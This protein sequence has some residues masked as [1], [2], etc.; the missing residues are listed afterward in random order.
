MNNRV[1]IEEYFKVFNPEPSKYVERDISGYLKT[2]RRELTITLIEGSQ[3]PLSQKVI[4]FFTREGMIDY[5]G[6]DID[7]HDSNG[8][9]DNLPTQILVERFNITVKIIGEHPSL[10]FRSPRGIHAYWFFIKPIPNVLLHNTLDD[11]FEGIKHIEILPTS[12][13]SLRVPSQDNYFDNNLQKRDFPGFDCLVRYPYKAIFKNGFIHGKENSD[14]KKTYIPK[15]NYT[16]LSLIQ[17]ENSLLPLKN[18]Q[19]NAVYTKLVAKYKIHGL[20]ESQAYARF[21]DLINRSP[22]YTGPLIVDL[23]KRISTSYSRMASIGLSQAKS[24]SDLHRDPRIRMA[25]EFCIKRLGLD[26]PKRGKMKKSMITFLL[27]IISWKLACDNIFK[28]YETANYWEYLYNGSWFKHKEGYY[29]LPYSLLRKWNTHYDRPLNL[30]KG[31]GIL[32]ESPYNYSTTLK[33]CKYYRIYILSN[34]D[35]EIKSYGNNKWR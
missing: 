27:N 8:W 3:R 29:P 2:V 6:M 22:G 20:D 34:I 5:F 14:S 10:I 9:C 15:T 12:K 13:R 23:E 32:E 21:V 33:R 11:L 26:V 16:P 19:T 25:L 1:F 30:L 31:I 18:G 7:D 17:I 35:T 4:S 28:N 24:L